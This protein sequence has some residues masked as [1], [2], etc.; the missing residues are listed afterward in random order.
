VSFFTGLLL[1]ITRLA[2]QYGAI[3]RFWLL[4]DL[5]I[6]LQDP[7]YVQVNNGKYVTRFGKDFIHAGMN[8][9]YQLDVRLGG[10]HSRPEESGDKKSL[11]PF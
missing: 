10:T 11:D 4:S 5:Y 7:D 1:N 6:A 2:H 8:T 9:L 3:F